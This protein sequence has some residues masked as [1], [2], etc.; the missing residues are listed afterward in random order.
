VE[1]SD[2]AASQRRL[3]MIALIAVVG[4]AAIG[5]YWWWQQNAAPTPAPV[6]EAPIAPVQ[7]VITPPAEAEP[8]I[9]HP[10]DV[11]QAAEPLPPVDDSDSLLAAA[12]I[13]LVGDKQWSALFFPER[14]V[15]RIVATVDNLP[16]HD[17]PVKM[18]P[19]RPVGSWFETATKGET[20]IVSPNNAGRY[21]R[22]VKLVNAID[23][24]KLA[25]SYRRFY[26]LFQQSYRDL[27][28]PQGY[29]NDRLIVAI[30]DLLATPEPKGP[31]HLSQDKVLFQFADPDLE[32]RSAGQKIMLRIGPDNARVVKAKL[33]EV[34]QAL[35]K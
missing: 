4:A 8:E 1:R 25:A 2:R 23:A 10:V 5:A 27:G 14:V 15:R 30:D 35:L 24:G 11:A 31:L 32:R 28:Y 29:F 13:N 21:A 22:Y 3:A 18:W 20:L 7:G 6:A 17:A 16:R 26:P 12:I 9:E 33:R 34:R 19:V